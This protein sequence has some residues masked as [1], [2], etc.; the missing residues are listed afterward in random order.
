MDFLHGGGERVCGF[1][2]LVFENE[3]AEAEQFLRNVIA[4]A[5]TRPLF[6]TLASAPDP[7]VVG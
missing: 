7:G 2:H 3:L 5:W 6:R 4:A 1:Q